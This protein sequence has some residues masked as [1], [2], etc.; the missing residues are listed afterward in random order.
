[1]APCVCYFFFSRHQLNCEHK[2]NWILPPL[3]PL[4]SIFFFFRDVCW[5][6][7]FHIVIRMNCYYYNQVVLHFIITATFNRIFF[8][9]FGMATRKPN[10]NKM[11]LN[12]GN[13][14]R[15]SCGACT[16][17]WII[18]ERFS[19]FPNWNGDHFRRLS[20]LSTKIT[21]DLSFQGRLCVSRYKF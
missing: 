11:K 7:Y 9:D 21:F 17:I 14:K 6:V 15:F 10:A 13:W 16:P 3:L 8:F 19:I 1:M 2:P 18:F 4:T 20:F 12:N 5:R